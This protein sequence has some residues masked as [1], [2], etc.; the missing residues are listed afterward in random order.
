MAPAPILIALLLA[1]LLPEHPSPWVLV[2]SL[3]ATVYAAVFPLG[4]GLRWAQRRGVVRSASLLQ[5]DVLPGPGRIHVLDVREANAIAFPI[6]G[7]IG[8][9]QPALEI[10]DR[11]ELAA[12]MR[13]ELGHLREPKMQ[14]Y[15]RLLPVWFL[16]ALGWWRPISTAWGTPAVL[17]VYASFLI[18]SAICRR[19]A[20]EAEVHADHHASGGDSPAYARALEKLGKWNLSGVVATKRSTH[21]GLHERMVAA[22]VTPDWAPPERKYSHWPKYAIF[23]VVLAF[24]ILF[25][26]NWTRES[27][28]DRGQALWHLARGGNDSGALFDL[29][30]F[31]LEARDDGTAL[32]FYRAATAADPRSPFAGIQSALVLVSMGRCAEAHVELDEALSRFVW[33]REPEAW[34][35]R[36]RSTIEAVQRCR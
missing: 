14:A 2:V 4:L 11:E 25:H 27:A 32:T 34:T 7:E 21:P 16:L 13:H 3:S 15:L 33:T 22:G 35:E 10:F 19:I 6:Q 1:C 9:T 18:V 12:V 31:A 8:V 20:R 17:A 24:L 23:V 28:R 26:A 5:R 29:A 36:M 30:G